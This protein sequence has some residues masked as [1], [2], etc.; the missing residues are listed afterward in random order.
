MPCLLLIEVSIIA[1]P[2]SRKHGGDWAGGDTLGESFR[3]GQRRSL[4]PN[5]HVRHLPSRHW[6][7]WAAEPRPCTVH[8]VSF[9]CSFSSSSTSLRH[10]N[11]TWALHESISPNWMRFPVGFIHISWTGRGTPGSGGSGDSG[12][13]GTWPSVP[14]QIG[15]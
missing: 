12:D 8:L 10:R 14:G 2:I 15:W 1:N 7:H 5:C 11:L 13:S 9:R 4:D 3:V 6:A